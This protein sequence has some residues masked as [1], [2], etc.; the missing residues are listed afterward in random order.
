V[1]TWKLSKSGLADSGELLEQVVFEA[2]LLGRV[3]L[4]NYSIKYLTSC[5]GA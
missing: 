4:V 3:H 5:Q 1:S 2:S